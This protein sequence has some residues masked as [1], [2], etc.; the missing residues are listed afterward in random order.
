MNTL[1]RGKS[2]VTY[3]RSKKLATYGILQCLYIDDSAFPFGTRDDLQQGMELIYHHFARFGMEMHIG[4]GSS[5]SRTEWVFFPPP[6]FFQHLERSNDA[7]SM[8]QRAFWQ[9]QRT[10]NAY[11]PH[12]NMLTEFKTPLHQVP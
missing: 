2:A 1:R 7:A 8:I 9:V 12:W 4:R 11:S 6:Q 10:R 3:Q 5:E